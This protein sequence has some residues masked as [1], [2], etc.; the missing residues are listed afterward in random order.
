MLVVCVWVYILA[1]FTAHQDETT[2][3]DTEG[4]KH[5][6]CKFLGAQE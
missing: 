6:N 4:V 1:Q 3:G 2:S 5:V